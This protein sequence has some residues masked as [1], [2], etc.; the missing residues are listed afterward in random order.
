MRAR[1][2]KPLSSF[3]GVTAAASSAARRHH[4]DGLFGRVEFDKLFPVNRPVRVAIFFHELLCKLVDSLR[5]GLQKIVVFLLG[6]VSE[7][8]DYFHI[9]RR[10]P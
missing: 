6:L 8:F 4:L 9:E 2:A 3:F 1:G 5:V 10:I 7:R